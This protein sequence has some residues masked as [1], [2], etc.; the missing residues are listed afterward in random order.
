MTTKR[1]VAPEAV[2]KCFSASACARD[3]SSLDGRKLVW[4]SFVT[5]ANDGENGTITAKA[6]IQTAITLHG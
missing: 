2:G 6:A 4:S 3:D 1:A 5:S